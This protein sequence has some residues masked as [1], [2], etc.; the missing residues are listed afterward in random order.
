MNDIP[1]K[2]YLD[3][4]NFKKLSPILQDRDR[5]IDLSG[6]LLQF[7]GFR[8]SRSQKCIMEEIYEGLI[9]DSTLRI[10]SEG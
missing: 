2:P 9:P 3:T 7:F 6:L 4:T 10:Y 5:F 1:M 8:D